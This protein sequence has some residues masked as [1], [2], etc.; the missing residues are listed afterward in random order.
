VADS[1][2]SGG[3]GEQLSSFEKRQQKVGLFLCF[4]SLVLCLYCC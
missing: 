1:R 2:Q 3:G 4:V